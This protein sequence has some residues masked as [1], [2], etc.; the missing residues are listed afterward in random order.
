MEDRGLWDKLTQGSRQLAVQA[1]SE[2]RRR[3]P[4]RKIKPL[5]SAEPKVPDEALREPDWLAGLAEQRRV[6]REELEARQSV[7]VPNEYPDWE[8]EGPA[9][10]QW[11]A[12]REAILQP[13]K[14]EIRPAEGAL[15]ATRGRDTEHEQA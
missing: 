12:Q 3:Y 5:E 13:P 11:H 2:I 15:E 10:P 6:F 7:P 8:H 1:D 4:D 14:A 9:W